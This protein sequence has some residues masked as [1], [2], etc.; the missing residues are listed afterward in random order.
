MGSTKC[1][2][3]GEVY[4]SWGGQVDCPNC[5]DRT[6]YACGHW[7]ESNGDPSED[8]HQCRSSDTDSDRSEVSG[9]G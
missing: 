6:E 5:R 7:D 8:C 4:D 1:S 9:D 2:N 3:C